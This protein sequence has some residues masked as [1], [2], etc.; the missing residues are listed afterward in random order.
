VLHNALGL[1][2]LIV[3]PALLAGSLLWYLLGEHMA[4]VDRQRLSASVER[5]AMLLQAED[6]RI[7]DAVKFI[8]ADNT[9][10][11]TLELRILPQLRRYLTARRELSG[12]DFLS[13]FGAEGEP[14]AHLG[15][16]ESP[17]QCRVSGHTE[18]VAATAA[19][20]YLLNTRDVVKN[21]Q[22]VGRICAGLKLDDAGLITRM[23][24]VAN[25]MPLLEIQGYRVAP[26]SVE[27]VSWDSYPVGELF[28]LQLDG[29]RYLGILGQVE[30]GVG[31]ALIG[32]LGP[33]LDM[34]QGFRHL[35][36]IALAIFLLVTLFGV[37][38]I[39]Y[40]YLHRSVEGRL[41]REQQRAM[42]TLSSIAEA[43]LAADGD[44]RINYINPAAEKLLAIPRKRLHGREWHRVLGGWDQRTGNSLVSALRE[45]LREPAPAGVVDYGT[46]LNAAGDEIDVQFSVAPLY[47]QEE[48][49]Q[50]VVLV[51]RDVRE[52]RRLQRQLER[53]ASR[54]DLTGLLNRSAFR[55]LVSEY[56]EQS[57][58]EDDTH[59]LLYLDLDDFK[60]V[61]DTCGH[62]VGD[63]ILQRVASV[64]KA[65]LGP[66][67]RIA[68]LGGD[69][70]GILLPKRDE[71]AS[72]TVAEALLEVLREQRVSCNGSAFSLTGSIGLLTIFPHS[73]DI[74]RV[75]SAVDG[76]CYAAKEQGRNHVYVYRATED[77][78]QRRVDDMA[79]VIRIREAL[80]EGRLD[81]FGQ[82]IVSL[83]G[84]EIHQEVLI[85]MRDRNGGLIPPGAFIPVA[86]RNGL[87]AEI[88]RA[89]ILNLFLRY[90]ERFQEAARQ[91]P[92]GMPFTINLSGA[93]LSEPG[94]ARFVKH[95]MAR[96]NIPSGT[97]C[98]E[99]TET[100]AVSR[101]DQATAVMTELREA[102]C[103]F[104][105]DDFGSGMS[106]FGYLKHLPVDFIKID[107]QFVEHMLQEPIDR[108]M[109]RAINEIGHILGLKTVAEYVSTVEVM[110]E[111]RRMGVDYA[112]GYGIAAPTPLA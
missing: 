61:N 62:R 24:Q 78:I 26:R 75:M 29:K 33:G 3:L 110:E 81:L 48:D 50:G 14:L 2:L 12:F 36:I 9:V 44:G 104:M 95:A 108:E 80:Q 87:M 16:T 41:L 92:M 52:E 111:L 103:R 105:L 84:D 67:D 106:S 93:T 96:Q 91:D 77:D 42:V 58:R 47:Q 15:S 57:R 99:V 101:L 21:G 70:F 73:G 76:A 88:D 10:Q 97:V 17:S 98:F 34:G 18:I 71:E 46:L 7:G 40:F 30:L 39:R 4:S 55:R 51:L 112:Q 59:G 82:P 5:L 74:E 28:S 22:V 68:R 49:Q 100:V 107:G 66:G 90:G 85:R 69:E 89:T 37:L 65:H 27:Q 94:F 56:L 32:V 35:F 11:V 64:L 53:R 86:E 102:G 8:A 79:W 23:Q 38:A 13:V 6:R 83:D 109:V 19:G 25:G 20:L 31:R 60:L 63:Q 43:V 54:D 1:L 45:R 72:V